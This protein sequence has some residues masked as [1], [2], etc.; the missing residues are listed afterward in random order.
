[1]NI[2]P[3]TMGEIIMCNVKEVTA[4]DKATDS[5]SSFV[6]ILQP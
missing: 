6:L 3:L 1:M 5:A 4:S 2:S